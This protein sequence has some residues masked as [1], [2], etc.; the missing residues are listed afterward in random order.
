MLLYRNRTHLT[1]GTEATV[2]F[3]D[4][5]LDHQRQILP[6]ASSALQCKMIVDVVELHFRSFRSEVN[7]RIGSGAGFQTEKIRTRCKEVTPARLG[8]RH[9]KAVTSVL[10]C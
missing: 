7:R 1:G 6:T 4:E 8:I 2:E 10:K 3:T 9:M 5:S